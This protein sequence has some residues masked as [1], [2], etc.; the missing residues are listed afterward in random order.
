MAASEASH[1]TIGSVGRLSLDHG[2]GPV[3]MVARPYAGQ[4]TGRERVRDG[5]PDLPSFCPRALPWIKRRHAGSGALPLWVQLCVT[6]SK[7]SKGSQMAE[8]P[9]NPHRDLRVFVDECSRRLTPTPV[10]LVGKIASLLADLDAAE[11]RLALVAA[12]ARD[13]TIGVA[14]LR[15]ELRATLGRREPPHSTRKVDGGGLPN[16]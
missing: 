2:A 6:T 16:G 11:T 13:T 1:P 8:L 12:L 7:R 5:G 3:V 15:K 9:G 10:E 14:V 4:R